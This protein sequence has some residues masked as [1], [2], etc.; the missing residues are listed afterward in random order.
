MT[1][2]KNNQD[3]G[4]SQIQI[5]EGLEAVR[6]RPG[7]YIG[8]TSVRGL[9]HMVTEIV[10]NSIDEH[11]AGHANNITI[12]IHKDNSITVVDDGRGIPVDMHEKQGIP[13]V[14]V[15]LTILH[16]GGKFGGD[17]SGY[18]V[19]GGLHGVGSSVVNALSESMV[20]TI[21][22]DGKVYQ[23]SFSRGKK[24]KDLEVIGE[25]DIDDTGTTILFKPDGEI[26]KD[27]LEYEY[28]TIFNRMRES[29]FLNKGLNITVIDERHYIKDENGDNTE[30]FVSDTVCYDRGIEEYVEYVNQNK[31][32][33]HNNVIFM[34][35]NNENVDVEVALQYHDGDGKDGIYSFTNNIKTPEGGTHETGFKTALTNSVKEYIQAH[36]LMKGKKEL[37]NGEDTRVGLTTIISVKVPEPQFEGQTKSKL[38]NSEV[39]P[40]VNQIVSHN[41]LKFFEENPNIARPL[42]DKIIQSCELRLYLKK[43]REMEKKK[44]KNLSTTSPDPEKLSPCESEDNDLIEIYLVEGDSAG[45][46]AKKGR[47]KQ[48]QAILPLRGKVINTEKANEDKINANNEIQD[49]I[50][51]IGAGI[52][53]EF[54]YEKRKYSKIVI[55]TDADVDGEHIK[56]LLL[57]FFFRHM[58]PLIEKG[59]IYVAK[60]P[61]YKIQQGRKVVYAHTEKDRIEKLKDFKSSPKPNIQR[62]KG[63]GEMDHVQLWDTTMDP[64]RRTLIQVSIEDA[65]EAEILFTDLMGDDPSARKRY[66]QENALQANLDV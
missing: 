18:K 42:I 19:S 32:P 35:D 16:A 60:P 37:P 13:A 1:D 43:Q 17:D 44:R 21:K 39:A 59:H 66:I 8:S 31:K 47:N 3:Y 33:I 11:L 36:D 25:C 51:A 2:K 40:I 15:I 24:V 4:A 9:H 48:F 22:R 49:I 64:E 29:A 52:G 57:T 28:K 20:A 14:E 55:M 38:G 61:L 41:L 10:D 27:T 58:R 65:A 62:Y 7:M 34:K 23:I 26:F 5:L 6:K 54:D 63:L 30:E 53:E 50:N 56:I 45:G 12:S 46:S